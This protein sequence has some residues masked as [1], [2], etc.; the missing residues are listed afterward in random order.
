MPAGEL[1]GA[2]PVWAGLTWAGLTWAGLTWAGLAAG[3]AATLVLRRPW[4]GWLAGHRYPG[5]VR[6]HPLFREANLLITGAWTGYFVAAAITAAFTPGWAAAIWAAPTPLLGW[7]S[8]RAGDWYTARRLGPA[9]PEGEPMDVSDSQAQLGRQISGLPDEA[10]LE[11]A[12][13]QPG[14]V[15]GL[16]ELTMA[17]MPE[18]L[19]PAAAQDC[20]IGYEITTAGD[21]LAYRIEV[22]DGRARAERRAPDDAR[23]VLQLSAADYL[24]LISGLIDGTA[25]FLAGKMR[26]RGDLMFAPQVGAMFRT[27]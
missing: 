2:A 15:A 17:G 20:V 4:T 8:F 25:A 14:G 7:A 5:Q 27:P 3:S 22:R 21:V 23:V 9:A 1:S 18:V 13:G 24:R 11:F 12:A 19:D 10:V 6:S 16:V 26:I